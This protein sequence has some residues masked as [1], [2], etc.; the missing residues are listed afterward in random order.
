[1]VA[2]GYLPQGNSE[3]GSHRLRR[4][5]GV[6]RSRR[7]RAAL[8]I[9]DP[10]LPRISSRWF[11][12]ATLEIPRTIAI[13]RTIRRP[14]S[15]NP[16]L[17]AA[18]TLL[19]TATSCTV[20]RQVFADGREIEWHKKVPGQLH[21][22]EALTQ[23]QGIGFPSIDNDELTTSPAAPQD[24]S[25]EQVLPASPSALDAAFQGIVPLRTRPHRGMSAPSTEGEVPL[26]TNADFQSAN[27]KP[28][29]EPE[30]EGNK[31]LLAGG[32]VITIV[33]LL[34][35]L[36]ISIILG[37]ILMLGGIAMIIAGSPRNS[38]AK[39]PKK[40]KGPSGEWQDVVYLQNGSVI[41]GMVIEQVP[42]VSLKIQ[43]ADG[44]VFVYEMKDVLKITKEQKP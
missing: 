29:G 3:C 2:C 42:N 14:M 19:L 30:R 12:S 33:G 36:F 1:M 20:E 38:S 31:G 22:Q 21:D 32:W 34:L 26:L 9:H 4:A 27:P 24:V 18:V 5:Y 11:G 28:E 39:A 37:L 44:S 25:V 40:E 15:N 35:L 7:L 13:F 23:E 6:A 8:T 43:T 16:K 10:P 41:R 17:I